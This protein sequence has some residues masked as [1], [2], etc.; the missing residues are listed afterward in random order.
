MH[1]KMNVLSAKALLLSLGLCLLQGLNA[2]NKPEF[3]HE[4][5]RKW[6]DSVFQ[7][8]TIE[9]KIGQL[10]MPRGNY[11]GKAH[12]VE[13]LTMW[14]EKYKIGGLVFFAGNPTTQVW[15]T[16]QLQNIS[17]I[18]L[19]IGQD[20]EWGTAMRLDSTTRFPYALSL[21]AIEEE[22]YLIEQM[23]IQIGKHCNRLGVHV[24]YAPVTDIN[25]NPSNPVINFRSFGENKE[26]VARKALSYYKGLSSQKII[27]TAKHFPGHGDTKVDS[28]LDL[29]VINSSREQLQ[30]FELFPF[31]KLINAGI[32]GI[33]TAHIHVPAL[34][35][36]PNVPSTLSRKTITDLLRNE[37]KFDGLV[38]TDAMDMQG[39]IKHFNQGEAIILA[40]IAGNDII[41]TF[42]DVPAA[43]ESIKKA[44]E[45]GRLTKDWLDFK[46]RKILKAKSWVG[47][48]AY[49]PIPEENLLKDLNDYHS[50]ILNNRLAASSITLIKNENNLLPLRTSGQRV[51][52]V[53]L[54]PPNRNELAV[55]IQNYTSFD[56]FI[57]PSQDVDSISATKWMQQL[58]G[59]DVVLVA[60]F[61][62][63]IRPSQNFGL[64]D[65]YIGWLN[66]CS[67]LPKAVLIWLGNVYGLEKIQFSGYTSILCGYQETPYIQKTIGQALFGAIPLKGRLPVTVHP[68]VR[69]GYGLKTD[70]R[71]ELSYTPVTENTQAMAEL[72]FTV[73]SLLDDAM[74][75]QFFPGAV[76]QVI[77]KDKV[78]LQKAFGQPTY[79]DNLSDNQT[80][81]DKNS[82]QDVMDV[83]TSGTVRTS[84]KR[85]PQQQEIRVHD[86]FDLASLTKIA[87][88]ALAVMRWV[89]E[90]KLDIDTS[91]SA[92]FPEWKEYPVAKL[93][94]RDMLAHRSGLQ[95]WIPFWKT[96]IDSMA[97]LQQAVQKYPE[98]IP[99]CAVKIKKPFF[100]FRWFGKKPKTIILYEKTIR[101]NK[102]ELWDFVFQSKTYLWKK[103][104]YAETPDPAFSVPLTD[105][106]WLRSDFP[107]KILQT[108]LQS[109]PG[110]KGTYLYSD[111]HYYFYP[112]LC[113]KIT[114]KPFDEYLKEIYRDMNLF[115][116]TFNPVQTTS[117]QNIVPTER[118]STFRNALIHGFV[119]DEGAIMMGGV[120][121][122]AGLFG[123]ANDLSKLLYMYLK[124]GMYHD[125]KYLSSEVIDAFTRYQFPEENNRRGLAFD[126]KDV[127]GRVNNAPSLASSS[128]FGHSGYTGTYAWVDPA[129][130][131][132]IV[133]LSNRVYPTRKNNGINE[134]FFRQ[135]LCDEIYEYV[136]KTD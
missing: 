34:D 49:K 58:S 69:E 36:T 45:E 61:L 125:K 85:R 119:H 18:P 14:I 37:M 19:L 8:M 54:T 130:D 79:N 64:T 73:D 29:P 72:A 132:V 25:N 68:E 108:I 77:H 126:K 97:S 23:G 114:G 120:S 87:A 111:L 40:L 102:K 41:E 84:D 43:V 94:F 42:M 12:D 78:I 98:I 53:S 133:F 89:D 44:I 99:M 11:S 6:V 39:I 131:L 66:E 50:V 115:S 56:N 136:L 109:K 13:Q 47:L 1:F 7:K 46:V 113:K 90:G 93:T 129:H 81:A 101:D 2:Q 124:K 28:H 122:H 100:L 92:Y 63:K 88:S 38:F 3:L 20:F 60:P 71:K 22:D 128:A 134:G 116:L 76:L 105:S 24:N 26:D 135:K 103:G 118:D 5:D 16:N 10:L 127:T 21:G 55:M 123:N 86:V 32:P 57:L 67:K 117:L 17:D 59:Y 15:L 112:A 121:G 95:A 106:L 91:L 80:K 107:D 48:H 52:L 62:S 74:K 110:P 104:I 35:S 27:C 31:R 30:S 33:M 82:M 96:T 9:Q 51:A 75:N 83:S 65:K 4:Y 70:T